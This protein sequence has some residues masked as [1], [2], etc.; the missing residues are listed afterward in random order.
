[1]VMYQV[2]LIKM[3]AAVVAAFDLGLRRDQLMQLLEVMKVDLDLQRDQLKQRLF[4]VK[5]DS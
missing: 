5:V 2:N 4:V 3:V 1:M